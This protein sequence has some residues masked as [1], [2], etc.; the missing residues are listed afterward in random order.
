MW[1]FGRKGW[2]ALH[3]CTAG[4]G[5]RGSPSTNH[6]HSRLTL[7][8]YPAPPHAALPLSPG[9]NARSLAPTIVS[10]DLNILFHGNFMETPWPCPWGGFLEGRLIITA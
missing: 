8:P 2:E 6:L 3:P 10:G 5:G 4:S 1:H 7:A 9:S